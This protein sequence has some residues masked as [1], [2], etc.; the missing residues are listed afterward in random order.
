VPA[1]DCFVAGGPELLREAELPV[2][3][4]VNADPRCCEGGEVEHEM[5]ATMRLG[6]VQTAHRL[7]GGHLPGRAR[8]AEL[9]DALGLGPNAKAWGF[10]SLAGHQSTTCPPRSE[11]RKGGC[12][13]AELPLAD[14]ILVHLT[15]TPRVVMDVVVAGLLGLRVP[16]CGLPT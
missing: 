6:R 2:V 8:L 16:N 4:E 9:V 3:I 11:R 15:A 1:T 7:P 12:N 10:E 13:A 5:V 14:E